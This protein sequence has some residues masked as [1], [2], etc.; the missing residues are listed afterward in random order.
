VNARRFDDGTVVVVLA[1]GEEVM[2]SLTSVAREHAVEG[3]RVAGI[4]AL[5]GATLGFYDLAR[6]DYDRFRI[7][8]EVELL[9]LLGNISR[10]EGRPRVHLHATVSGRDGAARGGHVFDAVVGATCELF[11]SPLPAA[12]ERLQDDGVGLPLIAP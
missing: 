8:E 4:G 12:L 2:E 6:K 5:R 1:T 9:S 7:E 10:F 3:A 11:V